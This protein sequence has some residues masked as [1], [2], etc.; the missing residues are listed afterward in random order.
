MTQTTEHSKCGD[1]CDAG[2]HGWR[3]LARATSARAAVDGGSVRAVG[4]VR[5]RNNRVGDQTDHGE[6]DGDGRE[7]LRC[8]QT[9]ELACAESQEEAS[10]RALRYANGSGL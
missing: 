2:V 10:K 3:V 8:L 9:C 1:E 7:R 4:D 6:S 5:R